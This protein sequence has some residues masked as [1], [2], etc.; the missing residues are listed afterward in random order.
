MGAESRDRIKASQP[1]VVATAMDEKDVQ[2]FRQL[3]SDTWNAGHDVV[4]HI[5]LRSQ[6]C[7]RTFLT[8]AQVDEVVLFLPRNTLPCSF[9]S[10]LR[11][12][13]GLMIDESFDSVALSLS[14]SHCPSSEGSCP[15]KRQHIYGLL[16]NTPA[17]YSTLFVP[18]H[19][20]VQPVRRLFRLPPPSLPSKTYSYTTGLYCPA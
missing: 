4:V 18:S 10:S 6:K 11:T 2:L 16:Y 14:Y 9:A 7:I 19:L 3:S 17:T 5:L 13:P 15:Y 20:V 12:R 8:A 1:L